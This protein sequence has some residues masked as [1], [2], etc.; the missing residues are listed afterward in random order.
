MP[1]QAVAFDQNTRNE[2]D[3]PGKENTSSP[4]DTISMCRAMSFGGRVSMFI[5]LIYRITQ[6]QCYSVKQYKFWCILNI[7]I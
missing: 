7:Y 6:K 4:S 5:G 3:V 2:S 1:Q